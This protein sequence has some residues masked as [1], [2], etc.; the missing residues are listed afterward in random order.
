VPAPIGGI[1]FNTTPTYKPQS[2]FDFQSLNLGLHQELVEFALFQ[3]G[4][5]MFN[6]SDFQSAGL[7]EDDVALLNFM[8]TQ[9]IDHA[10]LFNNILFREYIAVV[11][12]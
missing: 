5:T 6:Q 10:A 2:D 7:N 12:C 11:F 1:G 8:A 9:E 4:L 3:H